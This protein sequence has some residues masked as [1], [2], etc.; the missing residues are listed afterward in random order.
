VATGPLEGIR[1][2]LVKLRQK[3]EHPTGL[4]KQFG[5][6]LV[7]ESQLSFQKQALGT[8]Q[9]N[10]R[11]PTQARHFMNIAGAIMDLEKGPRI[12]GRRFENRPALIDTAMLSRSVTFEAGAPDAH[13]VT[14]GSKR[15][16]MAKHQWGGETR[17]PVTATIK[18][19]LRK[20]FAEADKRMA[21]D[22]RTRGDYL[23]AIRTVKK[24]TQQKFV[25][26]EEHRSE[27]GSLRR[28]RPLLPAHVTEW[29]TK[30]NQRPFI[31]ITDDAADKMVKS[32]Q[33]YFGSINP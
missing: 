27:M 8:F 19:N 3:L 13:T 14:I 22:R 12:K 11:Y 25:S 29:V 24:G 7:G 9:W 4:L 30:V 32:T 23:R 28:L 26:V 17:Q 15:Q 10:T 33:R 31:G 5:I 21:D 1:I 16:G 2:G 18:S 20:V 6:L